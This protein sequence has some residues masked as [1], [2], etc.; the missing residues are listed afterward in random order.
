[1][2]AILQMAVLTVVADDGFLWQNRHRRRRPPLPFSKC[3][4]RLFMKRSGCK[5]GTGAIEQKEWKQRVVYSRVQ[6]GEE[7]KK[8]NGSGSGAGEE[9]GTMI[10]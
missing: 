4:L 6:K 7:K 5:P 9:K 3:P 1:M 2:Y 8:H 10:N